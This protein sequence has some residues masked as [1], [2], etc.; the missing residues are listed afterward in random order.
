MVYNKE[1]FVAELDEDRNFVKFHKITANGYEDV[2]TSLTNKHK[3]KY[4]ISQ[5]TNIA[6]EPSTHYVVFT[7]LDTAAI[8]KLMSLQSLRKHYVD[9]IQAIEKH[10][11]DSIPE[12]VNS[13]LDTYIDKYPEVF[14]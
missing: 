11:K 10:L 14:I 6:T 4:R 5:H 1:P 13:T 9:K 3:T 12:E 8:S 7:S 2:S